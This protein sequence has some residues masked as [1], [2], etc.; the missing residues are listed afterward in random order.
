MLMKVTVSG[1]LM[2]QSRLIK[3]SIISPRRRRDF[4]FI[5]EIMVSRAECSFDF[6]F[7]FNVGINVLLIICTT[8]SLF[9]SAIHTVFFFV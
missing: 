4:P 8:F 7:T 6:A 1:W 5:L 2:T 9:F 3:F